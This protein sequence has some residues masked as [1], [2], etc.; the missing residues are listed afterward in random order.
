MKV[1]LREMRKLVQSL[2][3]LQTT[4]PVP[5]NRNLI[6][7]VREGMLLRSEK[8]EDLLQWLVTARKALQATRSEIE[9]KK[10]ELDSY[11]V[12]IDKLLATYSVSD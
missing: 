9:K 5:I 12:E 10:K 8:E 11:L 2:R 7:V 3:T 4:L 6:G 1:N